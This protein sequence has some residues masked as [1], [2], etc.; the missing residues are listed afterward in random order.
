M[1]QSK[2]CILVINAGSSSVKFQVFSRDP[3][4]PLLAQGK[5]YDLG[6]KPFFTVTHERHTTQ[7]HADTTA[8]STDA[9]PESALRFI[10]HWMEAQNQRWHVST[11]AHRVVHGGT[12]FT[13]SVRITPD[14]MIQLEALCPLAPLHQPHNLAAIKMISELRPDIMQIA[15]FD[16]A[17]HAHHEPL[18]T[19]YALPQIL[20]DQGIR[21]YG[22]HG[23]SYEWIA[24]TLQQNEPKLARGRIIA[25]HLG[26]GASLCA[27]HHGISVDTTM[28]MTALDGVPM[29]TRCGSLDPGAVIYMLRELHLSLQETESLLYHKSG[30]L[31][32]SHWT[33]DVR[34][35]QDS[36]EPEARFA[37]DYFC[38]RTAQLM[39][40]MAVALGGVDG[41]VFTGGIGENSVFVRDK[42]L[43]HLAFLKPFEMRII[44]ANEEWIMAMHTLSLLES[45]KE[46][47][48]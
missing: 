5:V 42:V 44:P 18:F 16:T 15:C 26:N 30:L 17:F 34:L 39:G 8:L 29:G 38:M 40:M 22:F 13:S 43:H 47:N 21:R 31:G 27:M 1:T 2:E 20:R 37:L 45:N 3:A 41:I 28:G 6:S 10:L 9:T 35:L 4:L 14:V 24:H 23:L 48:R 25:A 12:Y 19:E 11:V 32:L 36:S 7:N 46:H 33:Q